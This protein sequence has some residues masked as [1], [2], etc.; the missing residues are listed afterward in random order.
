M[1]AWCKAIVVISLVN[2]FA[3]TS[4]S[5]EAKERKLLNSVKVGMTVNQ[6]TQ[7][8]G[9]PDTICKNVGES[10]GFEYLYFLH[11]KSGLKSTTPT[12]CFDS[13]G[14]VTFVTYGDGG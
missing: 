1:Y 4:K 7:L 3:C 11:G 13:V 5:T 9:R 8:L 6:V 10:G 14:I 2:L 12:I